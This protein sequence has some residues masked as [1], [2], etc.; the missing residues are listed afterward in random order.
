MSPQPFLADRKVAVKMVVSV[1]QKM[2]LAGSTGLIK[3]VSDP[4]SKVVFPN[5]P[6]CLTGAL[7]LARSAPNFRKRRK[8][9][10]QELGVVENTLGFR[11]SSSRALFTAEK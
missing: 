10:Q 4:R 2:F 7:E 5:S 11:V 3:P 9:T 6:K 8:A 1:S